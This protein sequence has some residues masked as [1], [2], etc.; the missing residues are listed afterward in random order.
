M[1]ISAR[2]RYA[3]KLL[4]DLAENQN[5]AYIPLSDVS[6]RQNISKKYLEQIVPLLQRAGII[7][8][9][10]GI[11]GGYQLSKSP[12]NCTVGDILRATDG[13]LLS[14]DDVV[15]ESDKQTL[16]VWEGIHSTIEKYIDSISIEDIMEHQKEY[17]DYVI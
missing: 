10:R 15:Y 6:K 9:N 3:L 16:F 7:N 14:V 11:K 12:A 8:A 2:G 17:F 13:E 4:V 5:D 1:K